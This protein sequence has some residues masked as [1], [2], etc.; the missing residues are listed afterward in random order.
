[1]EF[2]VFSIIPILL[3]YRLSKVNKSLRFLIV[4]CLSKTKPTLNMRKLFF[5]LFL[6]GMVQCSF[7]QQHV[8]KGKIRDTLEK[9]DLQ[10]AV[11]SLLGKSDST[12]YKFT[13]TDK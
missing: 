2:S 12:L 5:V 4:N 11:V 9:K 10:Y 13:R 7:A 1:M 3:K 6:A 8:L